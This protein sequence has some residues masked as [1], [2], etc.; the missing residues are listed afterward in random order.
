MNTFNY[1]KIKTIAF[2]ADDTLWIN[3][4]FFRQAEAKFCKLFS[5]YETENKI[6]QEVITTEI[7]NLAIYG[8]GVKGF[9]L[10]MLEC[11]LEVTNY[12]IDAKK[13]EEILDIG[14]D[15]LTKPV[16]LLPDVENV[17]K[18]LSNDYRLLLI[19]KGDLLDQEHKLEKSN[20]TKYF[21]HVEVVSEKKEK[22]Y[23]DLLDHLEVPVSEFLMVGNSLKSD[24]LPLLDI[25][26][27]AIHIPF[28]TTWEHEKVDCVKGYH[29]E[30]LETISEIP[31]RFA[32]FK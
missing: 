10:S 13:M 17:L 26:A 19:T 20:L 27:M 16:E 2:D 1:S 7:K 30:T 23:K 3:E 32:L 28:H 22:N 14:K 4:V 21:H 29:Y 15:M 31:M 6:L 24:V 12:Q 5:Q 8:Y 9:V 18:S 25:G 11:A